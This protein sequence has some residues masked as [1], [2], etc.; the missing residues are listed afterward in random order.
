MN[1]TIIGVI[2]LL[3]LVWTLFVQRIDS[4]EVDVVETRIVND[5]P[6][7]Y[8]R[9]I[10][11]ATFQQGKFTGYWYEKEGRLEILHAGQLV[12]TLYLVDE[13]RAEFH[14]QRWI[15]DKD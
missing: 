11:G 2:A 4:S 8:G 6:L 12:K 7:K 15:R 3:T 14:F 9:K 10:L 5:R 1:T 13:G